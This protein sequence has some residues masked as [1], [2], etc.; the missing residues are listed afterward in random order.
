MTNPASSVPSF[1]RDAFTSYSSFSNL[2]KQDVQKRALKWLQL[3]ITTEL[4]D[5]TILD[6]FTQQ[7][8]TGTS[9]SPGPDQSPLYLENLPGSYKGDKS[10]NGHQENALVFLQEVVPSQMQEDFKQRWNAKISNV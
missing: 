3:H 1:L 9:Q 4:T 10:I 2:Q 7:W 5:K 8:R 6:Q